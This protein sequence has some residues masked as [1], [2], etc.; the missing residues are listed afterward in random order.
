MLRRFDPDRCDAPAASPIRIDCSDGDQGAGD[1]GG[2]TS[3]TQSTPPPA[4]SSGSSGPDLSALVAAVQGLTGRL[5]AIEDTITRPDPPKDNGNPGTQGPD[6]KLSRQLEQAR[7]QA[8][9][10]QTARDSALA[11]AKAALVRSQLPSI[12]SA[13]YLK[14]APAVEL[15]DTGA[16]LSKDSVDAL[17]KW[18]DDNPALFKAS[19]ASAAWSPT[20][21]G[22]SGSTSYTPEQTTAFANAG[23][24]P[25]A[26]KERLKGNPALI[27][28]IEAARTRRK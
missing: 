15:D 14:L 8:A 9:E 20:T 11:M 23:I 4:A 24:S 3:D 27:A 28:S 18:A 25:G 5:D 2:T 12:A 10:L 13:D 26:W 7:K 19:G 6:P 1:S 22:R 16:A 21:A 17:Q